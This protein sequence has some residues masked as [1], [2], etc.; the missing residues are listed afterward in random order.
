MQ[1]S[2][3]R[4]FAASYDLTT[5]IVSTVVCVMM[6]AIAFGIDSW[7]VGAIALLSILVAYAYSPRSYCV[8]GQSV[9]ILRLAGSV[10]L[11][12]DPVREA[13]RATRQ[14]L[15]GCIRLWGSGGL[16]G[17]YGLFRTSVL[18]KSTWY[19]TNRANAVV[20][21]SGTKTVLLSPDDV[22]VCLGALA[23]AIGAT[24]A[25]SAAEVRP[26][27]AS[28]KLVGLIVG[29]LIGVAAIALTAAAVLYAPGPPS[30][31][32]TPESLTIHD[33]FY[34]VTLR[35]QAVDVGH[36]RIVDVNWERD[37][38][39]VARTN[40]FANAYYRSGWFR[41]GSGKTVRLY[42]AAG[43]QL[44][45]LPPKGDGA[46]VLLETPHPTQFLQRVRQEWAR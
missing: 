8:S 38:R 20:L 43:T 4:T 40:G 22:D 12:L 42:R 34:P 23:A 14:D 35:A 37:W 19:M 39:P 46:P 45:L 16:F 6:L 26:H 41:V 7:I 9:R 25:A 13:R 32:L 5:K 1:A 2:S 10:D 18:G 11:P 24:H 30:Y 29:A 27:D 3:E 44:V 15:R 28:G 33:R 36:M 31:T 21:R 17:Y